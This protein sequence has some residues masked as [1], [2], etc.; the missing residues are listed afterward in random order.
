MTFKASENSIVQLWLIKIIM[1][2][3]YLHLAEYTYGTRDRYI[4]KYYKIM[5]YIITVLPYQI[6]YMGEY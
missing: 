4:N 1:E 3:C 2:M 6:L 5:S